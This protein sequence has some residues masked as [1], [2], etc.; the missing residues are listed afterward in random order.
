MISIKEHS[1]QKK[2]YIAYNL[3]RMCTCVCERALCLISITDGHNINYKCY[4]YVCVS[5]NWNDV[6]HP[7]KLGYSCEQQQFHLKISVSY[8]FYYLCNKIYDNCPH[9]ELIDCNVCVTCDINTEAS[10]KN[11]IEIPLTSCQN[12][13]HFQKDSKKF[14]TIRLH[15]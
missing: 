7:K 2:K 15:S 13:P 10:L 3:V 11:L 14:S 6:T 1:F 5:N 9:K 4:L 8:A 12:A